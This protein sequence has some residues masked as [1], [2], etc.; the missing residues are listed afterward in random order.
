MELEEV[1]SQAQEYPETRAFLCLLDALTDVPVPPTLGAG[2][3][4]QTGFQPYLN[5]LR[6]SVLLRFDSRSYRFADEKVC[7]FVVANH[8]DVVIM[9]SGKLL[10]Q[11]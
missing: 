9:D 4:A 5:Y 8:G 1:E 7:T 10:Q 2:Q 11:R 6:D 3:R